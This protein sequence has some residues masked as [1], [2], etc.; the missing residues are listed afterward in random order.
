LHETAGL[1]RS[2]PFAT[3]ASQACYRGVSSQNRV[4]S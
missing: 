3:L 2:F 4:E 1:A